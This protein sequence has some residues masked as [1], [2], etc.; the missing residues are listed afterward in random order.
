MYFNNPVSQTSFTNRKPR[1]NAEL[2]AA[3]VAQ[4]VPPKVKKSE[5]KDRERKGE[6]RNLQKGRSVCWWMCHDLVEAE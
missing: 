3:Q 5:R 4:V 1:L 2:V 6:G